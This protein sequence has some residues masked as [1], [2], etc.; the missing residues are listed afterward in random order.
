MLAIHPGMNSGVVSIWDAIAHKR[1]RDIHSHS[2]RVGVMSWNPASSSSIL[3]TGSRDKHIHVHDIRIRGSFDTTAV[4]TSTSPSLGLNTSFSTS[5]PSF[6]INDGANGTTNITNSAAT[7]TGAAHPVESASHGPLQ[8]TEAVWDEYIQSLG[9]TDRQFHH[10][11]SFRSIPS[12]LHSPETPLVDL[13]SQSATRR[14]PSSQSI[15]SSPEEFPSRDVSPDL[16]TDINRDANANT[17]HRLD[18]LR[19]LSSV[20]EATAASLQTFNQSSFQTLI[21]PTAAMSNL[22]PALGL[23]QYA[24]TMLATANNPLTSIS[25][26]NGLYSLSSSAPDSGPVTSSC[27]PSLI[28][29]FSF[30]KQEVC[31]LKWSFDGKYLASGN[32][33][34]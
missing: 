2:A 25:P 7:M 13:I 33:F 34:M 6:A 23:D 10:L 18:A 32:Y 19:Y 16:A 14:E 31:G 9:F 12:L 5:V 22:N 20:A 17:D 1:I 3:A 26:A 8:L 11:P 4:T 28:H 27:H 24:N 30:H 15:F 29:N 21:R